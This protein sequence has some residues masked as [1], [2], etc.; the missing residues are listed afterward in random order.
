MSLIVILDPD[1]GVLL[2]LSCARHHKI[3]PHT[4]LLAKRKGQNNAEETYEL[5]DGPDDGLRHYGRR[6]F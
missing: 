5:A 1:A 3:R 2:E 6:A 4:T